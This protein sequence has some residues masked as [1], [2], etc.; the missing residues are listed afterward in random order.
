MKNN[1]MTAREF[2][3]YAGVEDSEANLF[4]LTRY[5]DSPIDFAHFPDANIPDGLAQNADEPA[6]FQEYL[7]RHGKSEEA[8]PM[9]ERNSEWTGYTIT[10]SDTGFV[11]SFWSRIQGETDGAKYLYQFDD[12]FTPDTILE[13]QW[14]E[15]MTYGEYLAGTIREQYKSAKE[16]GYK[17]NIKCLVKGDRV[18]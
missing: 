1:Q 9:F 7:D 11:V 14:N 15:S 4:A 16:T 5:T 12:T 10:K 3:A 17:T 8:S 18:N 2:L 6:G 13:A